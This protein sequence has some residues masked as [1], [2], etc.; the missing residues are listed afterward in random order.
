[1]KN[2]KNFIALGLMSGTSADGIDIALIETNGRD[3]IIL[4]S[5]DFYPFSRKFSEKIKKNFKKNFNKENLNKKDIKELEKEFTD[6]NYIAIKNFFKKKKI[7][8]DKV[9]V[10]GFHGQTI[11]HKPELGY[12]YQIGDSQRLANLL[13]IK[14]V[15]NFRSNDV[16]NGGEGAPLTPIFHYYL[17]KKIKKKICFLNLGGITNITWIDHTKKNGISDILAFDVGPCC[18]LLDDWVNYK[19]NEQYDNFGNYAKKGISNK[20]IIQTYLKNSFFLK[21]PPKSLDRSYFSI[22]A[23]K[24]LTLFNGATT[25]SKLV[26]DSLKKSLI[27]LPSKPNLFIVSGGGRKNSYLV[28]QIEKQIGYKIKLSEEFN[29]DG[30]SIEAY[31]FGFLSARRLLNLPISFPKTTKAKKPLIGGRIFNFIP[32]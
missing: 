13:K 22:S 5:S 7:N 1:M 11:S 21:K 12:S 19:K 28:D 18:S 29:W 16:K 14:V 3:N 32:M 25:L 30:D 24:H 4:K 9:D 20:K 17:T 27:F 15:S 8:K 26:V 31:A 23:I 2:S 6:I 10:I